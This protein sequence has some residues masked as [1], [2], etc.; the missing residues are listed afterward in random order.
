MS[1]TYAP[2]DDAPLSQLGVHDGRGVVPGRDAVHGFIA[3]F[4]YEH[5][6]PSEYDFA[7]V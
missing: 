1:I 4:P 5:L 3:H 6:Q 2:L 7:I